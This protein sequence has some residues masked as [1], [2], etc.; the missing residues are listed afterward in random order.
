MSSPHLRRFAGPC[1]ALALALVASACGDDGDAHADAAPSDAEHRVVTDVYGEVEVPADPQRVVFM[2]NTTL[3]NAVALDFPLERIVGVA[4]DGNLTATHYLPEHEAIAALPD[5]GAG[6]YG[7]MNLEAIAAAQPDL[8]V[9]L[10]FP[11]GE[12]DAGRE[13][14]DELATTGVPVFAAF[15]GYGDLDESMRL[16]ADVGAALGLEDRAGELEAT[17]RARVDEVVAGLP[18]ARPSMNAVRVFAPNDAWI[19]AHYFMD[20]IGLPREAPAPPELF[21]DVSDETLA[22][23]DADI[24]FVSGDGGPGA[25]LAALEAN[26][27]WA[28]LTA[29]R[30]GD[31]HAIDDQPWGTDYSYPALEIILE[32]IAEA[33]AAWTDG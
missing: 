26:P 22:L 14:R 4:F 31:V 25:S 12:D 16:L 15:N 10:G 17:F 1:L 30:N 21:L 2:D 6:I 32:E 9:T 11:E 27:L 20:T 3:G 7:D 23:A 24:I 33:V 18:A 8:I 19:Q 5:M 28:D 29:V 13:A